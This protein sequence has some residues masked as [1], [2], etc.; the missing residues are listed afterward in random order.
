MV[1]AVRERNV[2][3]CNPAVEPSGG[4]FIWRLV[5]VTLNSSKEWP[6]CWESVL[7]LSR[8]RP[9]NA[10]SYMLAAAEEV[11]GTV[12]AL[13]LPHPLVTGCHTRTPF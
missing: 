7:F 10:G 9:V 4:H 3:R 1:C 8:N 5:E 6:R 12:V 13:M 2:V 11:V